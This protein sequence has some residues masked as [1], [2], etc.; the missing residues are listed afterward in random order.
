MVLSRWPNGA[1]EWHTRCSFRGINPSFYVFPATTPSILS[2]LSVSSDFSEN[3]RHSRVF[4]SPATT[5][6]GGRRRPHRAPTG[7]GLPGAHHNF[8]LPEHFPQF[9]RHLS[10]IPAFF[11]R[12]R[13]LPATTAGGGRRRPCRAT[14][15]AALSERPHVRDT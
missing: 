2:F 13:R 6:G 5:A 1:A 7:A 12:R 14:P 15:C 10:N 11:S 8:E 9:S 4:C 3:F